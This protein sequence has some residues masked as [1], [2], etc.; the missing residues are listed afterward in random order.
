[1]LRRLLHAAGVPAPDLQHVIRTPGGRF[2]GTADLAWAEEKVLVEFDGDV[3][4]DRKAF[5][6]DLRRQNRLIGAGWVIL[7]F[8]SADVLGRPD[9]VIAEIR[10]APTGQ[11]GATAAGPDWSGRRGTAG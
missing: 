7:R 1:V 4:R 5:V 2:L 6:E 11:R 9:E 8:S 10:R 3:H